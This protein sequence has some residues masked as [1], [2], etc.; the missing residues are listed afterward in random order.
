MKDKI[1]ELNYSPDDVFDLDYSP[2]DV[3]EEPVVETKEEPVPPPV[4]E[5]KP[6]LT[7]V[8]AAPPPVTKKPKPKKKV[9]VKEKEPEGPSQLELVNKTLLNITSVLDVL[10]SRIEKL[11]NQKVSTPPAVANQQPVIHVHMPTPSKI[12]REIIR[13]KDGIITG[14]VDQPEDIED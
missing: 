6:V 13:N 14:I 3:R 4:V 12:K 11:E 1:F 2:D 9:E 10:V 5:E 7:E 8:K